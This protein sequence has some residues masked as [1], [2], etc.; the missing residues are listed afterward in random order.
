MSFNWLKHYLPSGLY[1]RA[2]LI[3]VLPVVTLQ[4]VISVIFIQR[5]F[6]GVTEQISGELAREIRYA[7]R[8]G[9]PAWRE[10]GLNLWDATG[11]EVPAQDALRWYDLSGY[12]V[13]RELRAKLPEVVH[14]NLPDNRDMQIYLRDGDALAMLDL[15][16]NRASASNPHQLLVHMLFFGIFMTLI[17]FLYLRNQLKPITRLAH[18]AEAFGRGQVVHYSPSGAIEVRAAGHAFLNMRARIERHIEQRTMMLSGVSHDLRTPLT[19]MRLGLSLLDDDDRIPLEKDVEEMQRLIDAFLDFARGNVET[20]EVEAMD[21]IALANS[22]VDDMQRAELPVT[23]TTE[24]EARFVALR[25]QALR[26]ATE[27]LIMNAV[28]YGTRCQV[29]VR[30]T[31]KTLRIRIED[32]GPGISP[33]QRDNAVRPFV[34][35]DPARNQDKGSGVGLGLAIAADI[36]RAHGGVLRLSSSD[37]LGGLCADIVIAC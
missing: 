6:E 21:P 32:D 12:I 5:H 26:R 10:L 1:G 3:L 24:G 30:L 20:A 35:L 11:Q 33:D 2:A 9:D 4:L 27:N 25:P 19:R 13:I 15:R 14:I 36:A 18:A 34:R 31:E 8:H 17:A 29:S 22:I 7:L 37:E 23:L 16:R 28:R